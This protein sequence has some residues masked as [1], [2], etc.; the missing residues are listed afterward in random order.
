MAGCV[1]CVQLGES[2]PYRFKLAALNRDYVFAVDDKGVALPISSHPFLAISCALQLLPNA[3][4]IM[5]RP[6]VP[7]VYLAPI[8]AR[9]GPTSRGHMAHVSRAC[10]EC[11]C[12]EGQF[13]ARVSQKSTSTMHNSEHAPPGAMKIQ[14]HSTGRARSEA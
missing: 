13:V 2:K 10:L 3:N 5:T 1:L 9:I 6:W 11:P 7:F 14:N 12:M 8:L 4:A